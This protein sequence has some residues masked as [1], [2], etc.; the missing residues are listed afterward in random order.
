VRIA[1]VLVLSNKIISERKCQRYFVVDRTPISTLGVY[2]KIS[3]N[4]IV[5]KV[6]VMLFQSL[7]MEEGR[8]S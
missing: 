6:I 5:T 1:F 4:Y 3:S 8:Y 7:T 2:I